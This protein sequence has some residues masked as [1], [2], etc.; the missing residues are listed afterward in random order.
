MSF[1]PESFGRYPKGTGAFFAPVALL[2]EALAEFGSLYDDAA[3][4][5]DD[6][7]L[8]L[9]LATRREIT[10]SPEVTCRHH[11]KAGVRAWCRQCYYRGTTF[12]DGYLGDSRRAGPTLVVVGLGAL[13]AAAVTIGAPRVAATGVIAGSVAAGGLTRWSGGTAS[14]SASVGLLSAPFGLLF[15]AGVVRGLRM[16]AQARR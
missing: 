3:L 11:V 10:L 6:T 9:D 16:A 2:R 14:E 8:L 1:G 13:V 5:S 4:A 12:V 7:R 15:G